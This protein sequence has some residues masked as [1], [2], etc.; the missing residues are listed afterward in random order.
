MNE[1]DPR[2]VLARE[3]TPATAS[4][5]R[6]ALFSGNF[7]YL[8]EGAN[9]ALNRLVGHLV[10]MGGEVRI[11]S[12]TTDTPAF[13]P[14]GDLVSVPS[15]TLPFRREFRI[16]LG[17]PQSIRRDVERFSPNLV[18]LSTPDW[19]GSAAQRF[20]RKAGVPVV[21]SMHTRF[22]TYFE[23]YGLGALRSWA[24]KRQQGVYRGCERVLVPNEASMRH[25]EEM[26]IAQDR[27]RIWSRGVDRRM[28]HPDRRDMLWRRSH[29]FADD[30]LVLLFFG[31][32]VRE[33][34]FACFADTV[35]L[36]RKRGL[37][38]KPLVVGEGP[39][40]RELADRL[41]DAVFTGH[42]DGEALARAVASADIL[43]NPSLTEAFG[44]VNTEAMAAGLCL[45][46]A[47][48][49]NTA[50]LVEDG[51][52]GFRCRP[53]PAAFAG[54]IADLSL[55][56]AK[57]RAV[58]DNAARSASAFEWPRILDSVVRVYSELVPTP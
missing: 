17:M 10:A 23:Y 12:P 4:G 30:D 31:R 33:K 19:L 57:R 15:F 36:L 27:L 25:L 8:R 56:P 43:L 38:A 18:H 2:S 32:I 53:Q 16:A 42:L 41:G 7:N 26:G 40:R 44:N 51:V 50:E 3:R 48:A 9:Q 29:G 13:E 37:R 5:L 35:E 20:A 21:G 24:W 11:Y 28:F 47:D 1:R 14:A 34:G 52:T 49:P 46:C 58:G 6:V 54:I 55:D 45:V 22:E 39:G